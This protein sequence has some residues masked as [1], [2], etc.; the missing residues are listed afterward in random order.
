MFFKIYFTND[1][2]SSSSNIQCIIHKVLSIAHSVYSLEMTNS[3]TSHFLFLRSVF[4]AENANGGYASIS[5]GQQQAASEA[6]VVP[7]HDEESY[8]AV[9]DYLAQVRTH[10]K[11]PFNHRFNHTVV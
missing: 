3:N 1:S 10:V 5:G 4:V 2:L 6:T 11:T 7:T 9:Y 8:M